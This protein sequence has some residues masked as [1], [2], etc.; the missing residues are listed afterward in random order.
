MEAEQR[1]RAR[2]SDSIDALK[3]LVPHQGRTNTAAFL[4]EVYDYIESLHSRIRRIEEAT[5][6]AEQPSL[7]AS[8]AKAADNVNAPPQTALAPNSAD[9]ASGDDADDATVERAQAMEGNFRVEGG[10][11][12]QAQ[13][14][15]DEQQREGFDLNMIAVE[16]TVREGAEP[17]DVSA[18]GTKTVN[19]LAGKKRRRDSFDSSVVKPASGVCGQDG[20]ADVGT[21][22][23]WLRQNELKTT[24][25][26]ARREGGE[27]AAVTVERQRVGG[28]AAW[29]EELPGLAPSPEHPRQQAE[30]QSND[31]VSASSHPSTA[32][33]PLATPLSASTSPSCSAGGSA[34]L[35]ASP[36]PRRR[37]SAPCKGRRGRP[38]LGARARTEISPSPLSSTGGNGCGVEEEMEDAA[39]RNAAGAHAAAAETTQVRDTDAGDADGQVDAAVEAASVLAMVGSSWCD[40]TQPNNAQ[41]PAAPPADAATPAAAVGPVARVAGP[42]NQR[43]AP[44]K[45]KQ[46]HLQSTRLQPLAAAPASTVATLPFGLPSFSMQLPMFTTMQPSALPAVQHPS[47]AS[48]AAAA[49][50][51]AAVAQQWGMAAAAAHIQAQ[52]AAQAHAQV[53]ALMQAVA[54]SG[55]TTANNG[56]ALLP[57]TSPTGASPAFVVS[58]TAPQQ[59]ALEVAPAANG[60]SAVPEAVAEEE[61]GRKRRRRGAGQAKVV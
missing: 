4:A 53:Q 48:A 8:G 26:D 42:A 7:P 32:P 34:A 12:A 31:G 27:L 37:V 43:Q 46:R 38:A 47:L 50:D 25:A 19:E 35:A 30:L 20:T 3:R 44:L 1:R 18:S 13:C 52:A 24:T 22:P 2:I 17:L 59:P 28:D 61:V 23:W 49:A 5:N 11:E 56:G 45:P 60:V 40:A 58:A 39:K 16:G 33:P 21:K 9:E 10:E 36:A 14:R 6:S 29:T 55:G 15:I 57:V 51:A 54:A 41:A